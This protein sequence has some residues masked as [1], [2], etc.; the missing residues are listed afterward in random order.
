MK[1]DYLIA[2]MLE[3]CNSQE[4]KDLTLST[5]YTEIMRELHKKSEM[6]DNLIKLSKLAN[7]LK[8]E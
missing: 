2:S 5:H 3:N 4:A 8:G 6:I 1:E 7:R